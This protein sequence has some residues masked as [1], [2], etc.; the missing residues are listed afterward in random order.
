L[1][2]N[3]FAKKLQTKIVST[4]N[5]RKKRFYE[6]AAHKIL[7]KLTPMW[8]FQNALAFLNYSRKRH[9]KMLI[10]MTPLVNA[11]GH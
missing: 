6:K 3:P 9:M 8:C 11:L 1:R 2:Q 5:L 7:V 10:K 4:K